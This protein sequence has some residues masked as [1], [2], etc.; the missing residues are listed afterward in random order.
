MKLLKL[1]VK[2]IVAIT[3]LLEVLLQYFELFQ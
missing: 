2:L 1:I 3:D